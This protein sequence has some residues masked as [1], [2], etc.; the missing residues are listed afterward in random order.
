[1]T[2]NSSVNSSVV[3]NSTVVQAVIL[4]LHG[5]IQAVNST[6]LCSSCRFYNSSFSSSP[7]KL[8]PS[9]TL[10][11]TDSHVN[12]NVTN[13]GSI[14]IYG[15]SLFSY[16]SNQGTITLGG[17]STLVLSG[18]NNSDV[19]NV[20]DGAS[21]EITGDFTSSGAIEGLGELVLQNGSL[22]ASMLYHTFVKLSHFFYYADLSLSSFLWTS[23]TVNSLW[24]NPS[25]VFL[26]RSSPGD[27]HGHILTTTLALQGRT[28]ISSTALLLSPG[29]SLFNFGTLALES[30]DIIPLDSKKRTAAQV[31]NNATTIVTG[32]SS[33]S[34]SYSQL[35]GKFLLQFSALFPN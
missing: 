16:I 9:S 13:F 34:C 33:I 4:E 22:S 2:F 32:D 21:L 28:N 19:I 10:L 17:N 12:T 24:L 5:D 27:T 3:L 11:C 6:L 30:A 29:T 20:A 18:G 1:M 26:I 7:L 35:G 31:V 14:T 15:T 8:S 23:G 25:S